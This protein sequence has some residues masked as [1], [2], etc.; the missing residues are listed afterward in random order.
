MLKRP[1]IENS[2]LVLIDVQEKLAPAMSAFEPMLQRQALV[3]NAAKELKLSVVANEQYP[4][5]L[6]HTMPVLSEAMP[7]GTPVIEK[8]SFSCFGS[9]D[10]RCELTKSAKKTLVLMGIETHVCVQQTAFD[11]L[12]AGYEVILLADAVSSRKDSDKDISLG[13]MRQN[14]VMVTTVESFLFAA[15]GAATHPAFKAISKLVR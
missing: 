10:F 9:D 6:G 15:M 1:Q 4:K 14:G 8:T 11:A 13:L 5:G 12:K 2:L 3:L 7:E